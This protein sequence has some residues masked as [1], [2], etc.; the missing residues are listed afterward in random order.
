M[1]LHPRETQ[2]TKPFH[3]GQ[4]IDFASATWVVSI[5]PALHEDQQP[6]ILQVIVVL[7]DV[8]VE[9]VNVVAY[10]FQL[11]YFHMVREVD[12][13]VIF[14]LVIQEDVETIVQLKKPPEFLAVS[15]NDERSFCVP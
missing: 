3:A 6:L 9:S 7:Q 8:V 12:L 13:Q 1:S 10:V 5:Y 4:L 11:L 15:S 14:S 2:M